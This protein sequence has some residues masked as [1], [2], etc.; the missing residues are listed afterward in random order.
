MQYY[1][2][3][4]TMHKM[5][6]L[7]KLNFALMLQFAD[8]PWTPDSQPAT[9]RPMHSSSTVMAP[10]KSGVLHPYCERRWPA[11]TV[12]RHLRFPSPAYC[13][14]SVSHL[15]Q[16]DVKTWVKPSVCKLHRGRAVVRIEYTHRFSLFFFSKYTSWQQCENFYDSNY[17][18]NDHGFIVFTFTYVHIYNHK[19]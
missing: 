5:Y 3:D 11:R 9:H 19:F 14:S 4:S 12:R 7:N 15:K 8:G 1:V 17:F 13:V 16:V 6:L 18:K 10:I 2:S